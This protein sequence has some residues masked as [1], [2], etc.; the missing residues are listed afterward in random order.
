MA[1]PQ[2]R[3]GDIGTKIKVIMIDGGTGN[4]L[5]ISTATSRQILMERSNGSLETKTGLL[6]TDGTDGIMYF[7]TIVTDLTTSGVYFFQGR[8]AFTDGTWSGTP[9]QESVLSNLDS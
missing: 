9:S 5:D 6:E 3:V 2:L 7:L 4:P 8:V 1:K